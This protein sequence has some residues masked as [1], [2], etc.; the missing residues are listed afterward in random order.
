MTD[1][2]L[3][4]R[5]FERSFKTYDDN[6]VIQKETAKKLVNLITGQKFDS[7]FEAGCATGILTK[8]I[9]SNLKFERYDAND[10]VE[11]SK[12]YIANI[13]EDFEFIPGDIETIEINKKY[14]LIISNACLQWCNDIRK[15]VE[16]LNG[17]LN[18]GGKLAFSIFGHDNLKE[19]KNIFQLPETNLILENFEKSA[20]I[21]T[22]IIELEFDSLT[23]IL[24]H[25]KNTGANAIKSYRLTKSSLKK[26]EEE[27]KKLYSKNGKL[28]LTYNPV[29]I[30]ISG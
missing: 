24:R 27:Y 22:E 20:I 15:T 26:Y 11:K 7:I 19:L 12:N 5:R 13:L 3:V 25:L 2:E 21:N 9:K 1:K 10:I 14:D 23:D 16:K 6:A 17:H 28:I 8:E 4:K 29:Y 18:K 30:V